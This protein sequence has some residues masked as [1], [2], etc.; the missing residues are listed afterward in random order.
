ML[1]LVGLGVY[2]EKDISLKGL[3]CVKS[4]DVVYVEFYTSHAMRIDKMEKLY[5]KNVQVLSRA[6]IEEYADETILRFA[7]K[8]NVVLLVPGDPMIATTHIDL[9][10]RAIDAGVKARII[11]GSSIF[12]SG[13]GLSGLQI[14][15]FGKSA[16]IPSWKSDV[17]SETMKLNKGHGLH[18]FF[19][20][21]PSLTIREA[22]DVLGLRKSLA[23]G[24][25]R[26]GSDN[27]VVKADL[28][29]KLR[30]YALGNPP[31]VLIVPGDLH[32]ME[33]E[34][35]VKLAGAPKDVF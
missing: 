31:H 11:N 14:Y 13:I 22:L 26:V 1:T 9:I 15:K 20:L 17:P 3:E 6:H 16:S 23:V 33:K 25:A 2:D 32:W 27:P 21:D 12:T 35:L 30:D 10:L 28:A 5:G 7:K 19:Y 4:A 8:A 29:E 18:T 24:L 34:A